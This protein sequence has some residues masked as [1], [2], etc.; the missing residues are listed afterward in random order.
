MQLAQVPATQFARHAADILR[1]VEQNKEPI[2][3]TR[4]GKQ[5]VKLSPIK[6][7]KRQKHNIFGC[8]AGTAETHGNILSTGECW[9]A[10]DEANE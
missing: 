5:I 2:T 10:A 8:M 3:I 1:R 4:F 7:E 6:Q 9:E